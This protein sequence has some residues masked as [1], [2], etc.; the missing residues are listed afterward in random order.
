MICLLCANDLDLAIAPSFTY[1]MASVPYSCVNRKT[2]RFSLLSNHPAVEIAGPPDMVT[3]VPGNVSFHPSD[4]L[5]EIEIAGT[6]PS[7]F[8]LNALRSSMFA[9]FRFSR[10]SVANPEWDR[11]VML[12]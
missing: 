7:I 9:V 12:G 6:V 3:R 10:S 1:T 5:H 2:N 8:G 4:A 11:F